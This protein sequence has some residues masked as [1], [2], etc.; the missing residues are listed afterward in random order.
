MTRTTGMLTL[1]FLTDYA[2]GYASREKS[3]GSTG[4]LNSVAC[5]VSSRSSTDFFTS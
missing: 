1:V 2:R 4:L 5:L 3:P